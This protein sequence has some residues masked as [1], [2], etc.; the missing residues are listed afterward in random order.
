[1]SDYREARI[2]DVP[3]VLRLQEKNLVTNLSEEQKLHGF[4][5]TPFTHEQLE[6][7][8]AL[9]G[10]FVAS[11]EGIITGYAVAAG[12]EYFT[13]RPMFELMIQLF[14]K[15]SYRGIAIDSKNSFQYG[16]VCI[17]MA[18]RGTDCFPSLFSTMKQ[19]MRERY[20]VGTT[21]INR[22]NSRSVRAHTQT[23]NIDIIN[24][25]SF[26][27]QEYYGLAFLLT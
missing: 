18:L 10:L 20:S 2:A 24:E 13:G 23:V 11:Q 9:H 26:N 25:F 3:G 19:G 5:T 17:D 1:L 8:I 21:F 15:L 6:K 12:W 14:S 27:N 4:V 7:L 22:I 16:P